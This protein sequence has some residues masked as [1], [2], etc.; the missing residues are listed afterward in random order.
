MSLRIV[1]ADPLKHREEMLSCLQQNLPD[2]PHAKRFEWLYLNNPAGIAKSWFVCDGTKIVGIASLF[3]RAVRLGSREW[4]CGQVGDF[5]VDV[6]FRSLG[7][8][9]MLQRATFDPIDHGSMAFCYDCPPHD[10][11]M[12]TFRRLNLAPNTEVHRY[13]R[14][15]RVERQLTRRLGDGPLTR[16]F[17]LAGN[18][19]LK[20]QRS[21]SKR[22]DGFQFQVTA[23]QGEFGRE[24]NIFDSSFS[25]EKVLRGRRLAADLNWRYRQDPIHDYQI[26]VARNDSGPLAYLVLMVVGEDAFVV[27]LFGSLSREVC[28]ALLNAAVVQLE[29]TAVQTV[30]TGLSEGSV[31]VSAFEFAGYRRRE[32]SASVVAYAKP[33]SEAASIL[34]A[35]LKWSFIYA[36]VMA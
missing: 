33:A 31:W 9:L 22:T 30:Q 13:A 35:G 2:L 7:P 16:A 12:S 3:P 25:E 10:A 8:A 5:G 23:L 28:L 14:L 36:D 21:L 1:S 20:T 34:G 15:L 32:K 17:G 29:G 26:L 18:A 19:V 4:V 11:G 27:D 24:F 6:G